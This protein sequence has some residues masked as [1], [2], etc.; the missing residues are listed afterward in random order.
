MTWMGG[1]TE[2][3]SFYHRYNF[4][5]HWAGKENG[6]TLKRKSRL[7][8]HCLLNWDREQNVFTMKRNLSFFL[9]PFI[10]FFQNMR[11]PQWEIQLVVI[12]L[13]LMPVDSFRSAAPSTIESKILTRG[14]CPRQVS[15]LDDTIT[16]W[17][18]FWIMHTCNVRT[19]SRTCLQKV[20]FGKLT[21]RQQ[22]RAHETALRVS[23]S[24]PDR[25]WL[26]LTLSHP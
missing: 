11:S 22:Q 21:Q 24:T 25:S 17:Y 16:S 2:S 19:T 1:W 8:S 3:V 18:I 10:F 4:L 14:F 15:K 5:W 26:C 12:G 13:C 7:E 9:S 20:S 23:A 6:N